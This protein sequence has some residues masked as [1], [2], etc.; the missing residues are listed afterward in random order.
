MNIDSKLIISLDR[1]SK[2]LLK[3][4]LGF[5]NMNEETNSMKDISFIKDI[6]F[7]TV[8]KFTEMYTKTLYKKIIRE[9]QG[10]IEENYISCFIEIT[11]NVYAYVIKEG[12]DLDEL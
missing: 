4:R 1:S 11:T 5:L 6:N 3:T 12:I 10:E 8:K 9:L 7:D 2:I